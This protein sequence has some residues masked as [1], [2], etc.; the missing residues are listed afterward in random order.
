MDRTDTGRRCAA[1]DPGDVLKAFAPSDAS[2]AKAMAARDDCEAHC[3]ATAGCQACSVQYDPPTGKSALVDKGSAGCTAEAPC[4]ACAGDCD[5]DADCAS[6][7][8]CYQ[9][10]VS[11]DEVPG[12]TAGGSGDIGDRDYCYAPPDTARTWTALKA[13]TMKDWFGQIPGDAS[14]KQGSPE[15]FENAN[16]SDYRGTA[17]KTTTGDTC[18]SWSQKAKVDGGNGYWTGSDGAADSGVGDHN[19]CRNPE[20][21]PGTAAWCY[22]TNPATRWDHCDVGTAAA[23]CTGELGPHH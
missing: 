21:E 6:G 10:E 22:T 8:K 16:A 20:D 17:S 14:R 12:C 23:S 5:S 1:A 7:L 4:T 3:L 18:L 9:R 2:N 11:V 19:Y 15:C 13:C